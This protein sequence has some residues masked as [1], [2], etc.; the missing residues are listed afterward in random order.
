M[1]SVAVHNPC[2]AIINNIRKHKRITLSHG[3]FIDLIITRI[4]I[5]ATIRSANNQF[6]F[7][8]IVKIDFFTNGIGMLHFTAQCH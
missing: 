2:G 3:K 1:H 4:K 5:Y 7:S 8:I 6:I